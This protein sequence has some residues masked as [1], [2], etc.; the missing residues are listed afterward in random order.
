MLGAHVTAHQ[1]KAAEGA[2]DKAEREADSVR[3]IRRNSRES[4]PIGVQKREISSWGHLVS[5]SL[6]TVAT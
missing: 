2:R 5:L 3:A 1:Q 4:F 6:E